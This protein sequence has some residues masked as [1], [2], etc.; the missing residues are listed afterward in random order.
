MC[1]LVDKPCAVVEFMMLFIVPGHSSPCQGMFFF[2]S[3]SK[4]VL[5]HLQM[6][7]SYLVPFV[8]GDNR[9]GW[10]IVKCTFCHN[11]II[12]IV[13]LSLSSG[14]ISSLIHFFILLMHLNTWWHHC[15]DLAVLYKVNLVVTWELI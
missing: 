2:K 3:R 7:D 4:S 12:L 5:Q 8:P 14:A 11:A 15:N 10:L 1:T 13:I 6:P 9:M